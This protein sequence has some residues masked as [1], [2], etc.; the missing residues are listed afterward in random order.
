MFPYVNTV[1]HRSGVE[2]NDSLYTP[3]STYQDAFS[4]QNRDGTLTSKAD[5]TSN[6]VIHPNN[7]MNILSIL[8]T[9]YN[10]LLDKCSEIL[11]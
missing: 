1:Q 11:L 3:P 8:N 5:N 7:T 9:K 4:R 2:V 10:L 6:V